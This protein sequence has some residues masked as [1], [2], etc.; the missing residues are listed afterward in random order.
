MSQFG[1]LAWKK[2]ANAPSAKSAHY[3]ELAQLAEPHVASF[4]ALFHHGSEASLLDAA[5]ADMPKVTVFDRPSDAASRNKLQ[6]KLI[7][8]DSASDSQCGS[9]V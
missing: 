3:P 8:G 1:T 5:I 7:Q 6:S 2:E 9:A 4:D